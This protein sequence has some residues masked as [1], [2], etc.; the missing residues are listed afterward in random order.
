MICLKI[1][2]PSLY[3]SGGWQGKVF[4][5]G[6]FRFPLLAPFYYE[7]TDPYPYNQN[8]LVTCEYYCEADEDLKVELWE[9]TIQYLKVK[10]TKGHSSD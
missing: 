10:S 9:E 1:A 8:N 6:G 5:S 3:K 4:F 7:G 2:L